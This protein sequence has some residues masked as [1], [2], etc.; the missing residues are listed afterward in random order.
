[1]NLTNSDLLPD[2]CL[3]CVSLGAAHLSDLLQQIAGSLQW[4]DLIEIRLDQLMDFSERSIQLI[5]C[6]SSVPLIWTLRRAS[7]GGGFQGKE[8]ER[9]HIF[10]SLILSHQAGDS[11]YIDLEADASQ[12]VIQEL[13]DLSPQMQWIISWHEH[14][15]TP[16]DL[17]EL[18][19]KVTLHR[20]NYYKIVTFANTAGDALRMLKFSQKHNAEKKQL[21]GICMGEFGISTR[22]LGSIA[23]HPL[24]F[25]SFEKGK[26]TASGQLTAEEMISFYRCKKSTASHLYTQKNKKGSVGVQKSVLSGNVVLPSSKSHTIRAILLAAFANGVSLIHFPLDSTD[27]RS[28]IQ[29]A[30]QFGAEVMEKGESLAIRGVGGYPKIPN[31]VIDAGN[32]GQVLRFAGALAALSEGY[33]VVTGDQSIRSI[34]PLQPLIE[35]LRSL[36]AWAISTRQNGYAPLIVKGPLRAGHAVVNGEDSQP[37]SALLM[38]AAFTEGVTEIEV[39]QGGEKP[40]LALTLSWLDR[41][42]VD[43]THRHLEYF[44]IQGKRFR[45]AFEFSVP[46]DLS[47]LAF[48]LA[49]A[50]TTQSELTISHVDMSDSQGDKALVYLLQQMGGEIEVDQRSGVLRVSGKKRL[51]GCTIDVNDFIDAVPILA[52]MGCYAEGETQL[53]NASIARHKECNRLSCIAVELKKMGAKVE[54]TEDGLKISPSYLKGSLVNS[55]GDHRIAMSLVVAGLGAEGITEIEGIEC[56]QKSYPRFLDDFIQLGAK[57]ITEVEGRGL[58][59]D[60]IS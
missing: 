35:G 5:R 29:A 37:V 16:M 3:L 44:T 14:Q 54:E 47:A 41:L 21:C 60:L 42:G 1:M 53:V 34:R 50:F 20:A 18:Y 31:N 9:F 38:A 40:W 33:T 57:F 4:A 48:P 2:R 24:T 49:A 13:Q 43:Y 32:S 55:Y 59:C 17:E 28:A 52:V 8:E 30:V 58:V 36:Q 26:E 46:G 56:I 19:Q 7:Q 10:R 12:E 11:E 6:C 22:I 39:L 27:T 51:K 45:P 15:E 25:A 23:G